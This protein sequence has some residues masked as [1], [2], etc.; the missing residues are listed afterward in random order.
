MLLTLKQNTSTCSKLTEFKTAEKP[1]PIHQFQFCFGLYRWPLCAPGKG[2]EGHRI[3]QVPLKGGSRSEGE[4]RKGGG[5][6][7]RG[8]EG[9]T[10]GQMEKRITTCVSVAELCCK[11]A[12]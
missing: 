8:T 4:G 7:R 6:G 3:H 12:N 10:D 1:S 11:G 2:E 5:E 9:W